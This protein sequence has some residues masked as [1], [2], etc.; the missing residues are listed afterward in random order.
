MHVEECAQ[1]MVP[2]YDVNGV[3]CRLTIERIFMVRNN[4]NEK[5][6]SKLQK[7]NLVK[8]FI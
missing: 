1:T 7:T 2:I 6:Q 3:V 5:K 4:N 8:L